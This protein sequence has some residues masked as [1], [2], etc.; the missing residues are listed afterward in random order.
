[1]AKEK[2]SISDGM[3]RHR[4]ARKEKRE[5]DQ[6]ERAHEVEEVTTWS[7]RLPES[8]QKRIKMQPIREDKTVQDLARELLSDAL[9][10]REG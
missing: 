8:L 6:P 5:D 9:D 1:M 2:P 4:Q 7:T 3:R 10:R